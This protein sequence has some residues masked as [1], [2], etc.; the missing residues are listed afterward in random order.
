MEMEIFNHITVTETKHKENPPQGIR[1]LA[2]KT[3]W[4]ISHRLTG[5]REVVIGSESKCSF[6]GLYHQ[7][8]KQN[9]GGRSDTITGGRWR[10]RSDNTASE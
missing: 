3:S 4:Y 1:W 8:V 2:K 6:H 7:R 9:W 5:K 10:Q